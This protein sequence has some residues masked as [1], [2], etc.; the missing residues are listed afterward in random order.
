MIINDF[1][2]AVT[3]LVNLCIGL[4]VF[5]KNKKNIVN[6]VFFL[7]M[8]GISMW[9][10][11]YFIARI[12]D[13]IYFWVRIAFTGAALLCSSFLHFSLVFPERKD[14][15]INKIELIFIYLPVFLSCIF[16]RLIVRMSY[17]LPIGFLNEY[18][19]LYFL[20]IFYLISYFIGGLSHF[21]KR[22]K[23]SF[24]VKKLQIKYLFW[25]S[26][27]SFI[28]AM[29]TNV[30]LPI[31]G[32]SAL[33]EIGPSS[34]I[35]FA[36]VTAYAILRHRL[37]DIEV[38]V[39]KSIVY[40][41]LVGGVA[42]A[43]VLLAFLFGQLLQGV[44]G[45][46]NSL[47]IFLIALLVVVGYRPLEKSIENMTDKVFFKR[48][49]DYRKALKEL[50]GEISTVIDLQQLF[51]LIVMGIAKTVKVDMVSM[52]IQEYDYIWSGLK[53]RHGVEGDQLSTIKM[54]IDGA[55][56]NY[57]SKHSELIITEE[58]IDEEI[59][60][61]LNKLEAS[62]C[63]PMLS[64]KGL[65][66]I[67]NIGNKLSEDPYTIEDLELLVTLANQASVAL[68]NAK[69][70]EKEKEMVIK[71]EQAERLTSLGRFA[72]GIV[73]EIKNPLVSIK[74]FFQVFSDEEESEKD[75]QELAELASQEI[76]LIEG[77]LENLLNFAKPSTLEFSFE[78]INEILNE[79]VL[80]VKPEL[81][82]KGVKL[83]IA[84]ETEHI[85]QMMVDKKQIKQVFL[86][87]VYNA[88]EAMPGGGEIHVTI[89]HKLPENQL[90]IKFADSGYGISRKDIKKLFD[91]FYTTKPGGTGMGL[92]VSYNIIK[93]HEGEITVKSEPGKGTV[94][95][96]RLPISIKSDK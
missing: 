87:L 26:L 11:G 3:A 91:P 47:A 19:P 14:I 30:I 66:G 45:F 68:E 25:G 18:G 78:D 65:L 69:L 4:F 82:L 41:L 70:V 60:T 49:Y 73:H 22:Y 17:R 21:I 5:L 12:S 33:V 58:V 27:L 48:K 93:K 50:S 20:F 72:A 40:S 39:K 24:G 71:L 8:F 29:F 76:V 37:M 75:K 96:I 53:G 55:F 42:G 57:L 36:A 80:L 2:M 34:T 28:I 38:I 51:R 67:I 59:K 9:G 90:V 35:I 63:V 7:F 16:M 77:L 56:I 46:G 43:Y 6:Q 95:E 94:F 83:F 86:N 13:Q 52:L 64:K 89:S 61:T 44:V 85:P 62:V 31:L 92:A 15:K 54:E 88:L 10:I 84:N 32:N 81:S 79:I 23:E 74:T 1:I